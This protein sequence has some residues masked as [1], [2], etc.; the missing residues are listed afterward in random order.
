MDYLWAFLIFVGISFLTT[1]LTGIFKS[2][3]PILYVLL[4]YILGVES[5]IL[6]AG[7][8]L[9]C[10]LNIYNTN[11]YIRTQ[12]T[13]SNAPIYSR[14]ASYQF[15]ISFIATVI[16]KYYFNFELF[17]DIN[18]WYL[19]IS[20]FF[21]W[22]ISIFIKNKMKKSSDNYLERVIKYKIVEKYDDNPKWAT[23]L[24]YDDGDECWNE[25][26]YGS[27]RAKDPENDL[28]FVFETKEKALFYAKETFK[29]AEYY[30][31]EENELNTLKEIINKTNI[32]L[33]SD[34]FE[35]FET[36]ILKKASENPN[37]LT[38]K[39]NSSDF[40]S[41]VF[42]YNE[43][44]SFVFSEIKTGNYHVKK[45]ELT[46]KGLELGH[47]YYNSVDYLFEKNKIPESKRN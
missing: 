36:Y 10:F 4:G 7:G 28:T 39:I 46:K 35:F 41:E 5:F 12:G 31:F 20:V 17:N 24:Y 19:F 2:L 32:Q 34:Y 18:Y 23:Y 6:G 15:I 33:D 1:I 13:L 43:L 45:G 27:F 26:I 16:A 22:G 11:K 37:W 21:V 47:L 42:I 40:G 30:D 9:G 38:N 44:I 3:I 8:L 29:N 25:T 14:N